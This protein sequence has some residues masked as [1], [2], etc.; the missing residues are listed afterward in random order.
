MGEFGMVRSQRMIFSQIEVVRMLV[1]IFVVP[2]FCLPVVPTDEAQKSAQGRKA[3][4]DGY[5]KLKHKLDNLKSSDPYFCEAQWTQLTTSLADIEDRIKKTS[6]AADEEH[7]STALESF[8]SDLNAAEAECLKATEASI[9]LELD[10]FERYIDYL[11]SHYAEMQDAVELKP[12]MDKLAAARQMVRQKKLLQARAMIPGPGGL[13]ESLAS[14]DPCQVSFGRAE[15][16][17]ERGALGD[18]VELYRETLQKCPCFDPT[19]DQKTKL[20]LEALANRGVD[21]KQGTT[22][23]AG[24]APETASKVDD[25]AG[26]TPSSRKPPAG[27]PVS[28]TDPRNSSDAGALLSISAWQSAWK[29]FSDLDLLT[30]YLTRNH[31][32]ALF[33]NPGMPIRADSF[34]MALLK[35]KPIVD[36]LHAAG[37]RRVCYLYAEPNYPIREYADFLVK[38]SRELGIDTIVDDSEFTDF[39]RSRF[40]ENNRIVKSKGLRYSAYV[41]LE[42]VGNSGVGDGTREW[43]IANIDEPILMSYFGCSLEEQKRWLEKYLQYADERGKRV[44]IAILM[45][46]KSVG[47]E[48]SCEKALDG[49]SFRKFLQDLHSWARTFPSYGGIVLETNQKTPGYDVAL[50]P[51]R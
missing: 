5:A 32:S 24:S 36:K 8:S 17:R 34:E 33:L 28:S 15:G 19:I 29:D 7:A 21:G 35:L 11:R 25:L 1:L 6:N 42:R 22:P 30:T 38:Y 18:A 50:T 2:A 4:Q 10:R 13:G 45:G 26:V 37:V 47:R 40:E 51:L 44:K 3:L 31:I 23:G 16:K 49:A 39:S 9:G 14:I 41:T 43:A 46:G 20:A 12:I 27:M 48:M